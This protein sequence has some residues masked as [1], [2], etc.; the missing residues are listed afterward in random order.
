MARDD[1]MGGDSA[2]WSDRFAQNSG[3]PPVADLPALARGAAAPGPAWTQASDDLHANLVVFDDNDGIDEHANPDL[4]VLLVG[5][6]GHGVV[7]I[8]GAA[9]GLWPGWTVL[10]PKG[11]R[12]AVRAAGGRFAYLTC[13]RR[14]PPL[15]PAGRARS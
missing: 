15:R 9:V 10:V 11:T 3:G 14:R 1:P 13:H 6:L 4:D 7:T 2:C 12:R 5:V 8:D